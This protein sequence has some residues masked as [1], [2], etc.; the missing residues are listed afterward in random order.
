MYQLTIIFALIAGTAA[1][2]VAILTWEVFRQSSF[3]RAIFF[4]SFFM[5]VFILYHA[6]LLVLEIPSIYVDAVE[7]IVYTGFAIVV[8][9]IAFTHPGRRETES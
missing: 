3:G 7:S 6:V 4:L 2:L 1:T 5:S 8:W 9:T